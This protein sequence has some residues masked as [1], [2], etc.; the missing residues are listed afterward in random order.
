MADAPGQFCSYPHPARPEDR[1]MLDIAH[2]YDAA[3]QHA[4]G[5]IHCAIACTT[6]Q[7]QRESR[8]KE[9]RADA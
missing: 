5:V 8:A 2:E 7:A 6:C 3:E 4:K 9:C 1:T